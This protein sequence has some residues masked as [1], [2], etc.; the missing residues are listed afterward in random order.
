MKACVVADAPPYLA[1][2]EERDPEGFLSFFILPRLPSA[3]GNAFAPGVR[4]PEADL[5]VLP[6]ELYLSLPA[7]A[8]PRPAFAYGP[9]RLMPAAFEAGCADYL[10]EPW[11]PSELRARARRLL[12]FRFAPGSGGVELKG[13]DLVSGGRTER[14]TEAERRLFRLLLLNLG[15]TVPCKA[16]ELALWGE[17]RPASRAPG[18]HVSSIRRKLE[19]LSP[20]AGKALRAHRGRGYS[21]EAARCG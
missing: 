10:R 4:P 3:T 13:R 12:S 8:R 19:S 1:Y 9:E 7:E 5:Y 11:G 14:L 20:G 18:V 17:E 2:G 16:L 21:F 6:A 15:E